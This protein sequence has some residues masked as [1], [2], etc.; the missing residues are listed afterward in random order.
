MCP[1]VHKPN[2][3]ILRGRGSRRCVH[4]SVAA[5]LIA[6]CSGPISPISP[7]PDPFL[8]KIFGV[9]GPVANVLCERSS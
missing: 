6:R 1:T 8:M 2:L 9:L 4:D 5:M 7:L 3:G